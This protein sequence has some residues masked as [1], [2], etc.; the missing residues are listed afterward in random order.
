MKM[1]KRERKKKVLFISGLVIVLC[2]C[3]TTGMSYAMFTDS[4]SVTNHLQAGNLDITLTRTKLEYC[5]LNDDGELEV[6]TVEENFDFTTST[7]E[8]VF[9]IDGADIRIVPGSYFDAELEI[10]NVGSTAFSYSI[11]IKLPRDANALAEQLKVIVTHPNGTKTEKM[12][13]ELADGLAI[14]T[15]RMKAGDSAQQ[16]GVCVEFIDDTSINNAAQS[17]TAT[18]DL[19]VTAVQATGRG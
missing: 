1:K 3:I 14:D 5:V 2:I 16:F 17:Q 9:G 12:L 10:A 8:N 13:S 6:V 18:F 19:V 11:N 15:G 4:I 7:D